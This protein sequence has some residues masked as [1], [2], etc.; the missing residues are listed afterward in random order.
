MIEITLEQAR[1]MIESLRDLGERLEQEWSAELDD[2]QIA[3]LKFLE[4]E[5]EKLE[6]PKAQ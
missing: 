1:L 6:T 4:Q 3:L 5:I 2:D